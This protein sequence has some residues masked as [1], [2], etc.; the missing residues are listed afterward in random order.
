[1]YFTLWLFRCCQSPLFQHFSFNG[2]IL[3]FGALW[4]IRYSWQKHSHLKH[5][6]QYLFSKMLP[7]A[8]FQILLYFSSCSRHTAEIQYFLYLFLVNLRGSL[9]GDLGGNRY[10]DLKNIPLKKFRT[11]AGIRL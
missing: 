1:M 8:Q 9:R 7:I 3:L 11:L 5:W 2:V 4:F 6:A 10:A